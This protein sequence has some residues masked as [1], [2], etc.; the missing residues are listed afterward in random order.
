MRVGQR[1]RGRPK[2]VAGVV[3]DVEPL[4]AIGTPG[5]GLVAAAH[6]VMVSGAGG[7]PEAE[8]ALDVTQ[9]VVT[10]GERNEGGEVVEG[11]EV[12]VARLKDDDGGGVRCGE[13][14]LQHFGGEAAIFAG[15]QRDKTAFAHAEETDG[16][17]EGAKLAVAGKCRS[18][19]SQ[20]PEISS[21]TAAA[22]AVA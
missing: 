12:E 8:C 13:G 7:G 9:G 14:L 15:R 17:K 18:S 5:V 20:R 11:S 16:A 2:G 4:V 1:R 21:T 19:F 6:E 10:M 3:G 22:G